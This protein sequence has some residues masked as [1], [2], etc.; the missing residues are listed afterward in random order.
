MNAAERIAVRA[1][2]LREVAGTLT[3]HAA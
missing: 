2:A 1:W 3:G